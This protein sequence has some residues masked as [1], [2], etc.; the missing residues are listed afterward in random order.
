[1]TAPSSMGTY[2]ITRK[3]P[4]DTVRTVSTSPTQAPWSLTAR[5]RIV[6]RQDDVIALQDI[7]N[8]A[9]ATSLRQLKFRSGV[10][11]LV[12]AVDA[13]AVKCVRYMVG[14]DWIRLD[15]SGRHQSFWLLATLVHLLWHC[16][17]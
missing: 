1:M 10:N 4:T 6:L 17:L 3:H 7:F 9:D 8:T 15:E 14:L 5:L 11:T 2:S 12:M 13:Y 16:R